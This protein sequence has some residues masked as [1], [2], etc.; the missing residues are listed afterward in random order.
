MRKRLNVIMVLAA[1]GILL[2]LLAI[3]IIFAEQATDTRSF[4]TMSPLVATAI[5][6]TATAKAWTVT[7]AP[8]PSHQGN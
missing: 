3:S 8:T 7:P 6:G 5:S 1:V 4:D 2:L